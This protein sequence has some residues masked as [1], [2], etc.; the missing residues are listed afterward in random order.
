LGFHPLGNRYEFQVPEK[1][2]L[3]GKY[4]NMGL[5]VQG[6][7]KTGKIREWESCVLSGK[8]CTD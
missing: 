4:I 6:T 7:R 3:R 1:N 8:Q 5:S 2:S